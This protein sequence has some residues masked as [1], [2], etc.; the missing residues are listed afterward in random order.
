MINCD[1][2]FY[3]GMGKR[4][5][6]AMSGGVDSSV[7]A[8]LLKEQGY[9]VIG[10]TIKLWSKELCGSDSARSCCNLKSV[11]DARLVAGK[12]KIPYYV[13][14]FEK[15]FRQE[16]IDYFIREYLCGRTP[17]PCIICNERI[18]WGYFLL[19]AKKIGADFIAT[20]HYAQK[21]YS[22]VKK[23]F[24]L[25]EAA[26]Q[27]KD[28]SYVLFSLTQEM[29]SKTILPL[30]GHTKSEV[31]NLAKETGLIIF[32]KAE[33]Q[34]ICFIPPK[35]RKHFFLK[36]F[37]QIQPGLIL[38]KEGKILGKHKGVIFYTVGQREGLQ[39]TH[40]YPL[41]VIKIDAENNTLVV[42]ERKDTMSDYLIAGDLNWIGMDKPR[43]K[44]RVEAK[45]RYRHPKAA[46]TVF[47]EANNRVKVI[48]DSPQFAITPGQAVVF[49][50]RDIVLGGGWI[51]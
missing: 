42:G 39:L 47:P 49:Y 34:D 32:D 14:N 22:R 20:G 31:R 48:F 1:A 21:D 29:L 41:Y 27:E 26:Y 24:L 2:S 46:A 50:R 3:S 17:N 5:L 38:N 51:E 12:L 9:D 33:S 6:V 13:F 16:V 25:K 4:I 19:S 11:E 36:F 37:P 7:A 44:I 45:I 40:K 43:R 15:E 28:Q 35:N 18:K 10:A 30:G 8:A 23:R